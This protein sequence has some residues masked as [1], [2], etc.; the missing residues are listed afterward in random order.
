MVPTKAAKTHLFEAE[1]DFVGDVQDE[2]GNSGIDR[3]YLLGKKKL[4][5]QANHMHHKDES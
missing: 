3:V 1:N 5:D 4:N 2:G